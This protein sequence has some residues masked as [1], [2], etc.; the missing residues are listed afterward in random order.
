MIETTRR[1][2]MAGA[3]FGAL[4]LLAAEPALAVEEVNVYSSRHYG[5]DEQLW[6]GFTKATGIKVNEVQA[7]H[8][9]LIQRMKAE[10]ANGP[11]DVFITVDAGRLAHA[12][13]EGLLA[14]TSSEA[15]EA[16]IPEHLRHPEGL[17]YGLATRARVLIYAKDRVE[18]SELSTYEALAEPDFKGRVLVRSSS[19]IYNLGLVGSLIE[20]NGYE[21]TLAWCKGLVDNMARPPEGG[22]TDQ[23]KAVAA[24]VGDVAISNSYYFARLV[25]SDEPANRE[26]AEKL[27]VFF[28]NQDGRGTHVNVTG[29]AVTKSAPHPENAV[30]L[31]EY[32]AS[33]EAQR[34]FADVSFEYPAN[35]EAEP[36]PVLESWGEFK[37]DPLNASSFAARNAE[38]LKLADQCG[39]K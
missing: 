25:A 17:W 34:Y 32:L 3:A 9:E 11:A 6:E 27:A 13:G 28:P 15:L 19:N 38:A 31:I 23:I 24:G 21:D 20:A 39:W 35:P 1:R 2:L 5:T 26:I 36:H 29:A 37:Q 33:P 7:N 30:K 10:G 16:A 12:A 14:P 22:D 18:P 8:D 4:A